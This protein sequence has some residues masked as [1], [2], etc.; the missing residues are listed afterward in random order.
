MS[1][2]PDYYRVLRVEP[3]APPALIHASFRTLMQRLRNAPSRGTHEEAALLTEAYAVLSDPERRAAYD[4]ARD[5][6]LSSRAADFAAT[7]V[8]SHPDTDFAATAV[9]APRGADF[10]ATAVL[11]PDAARYAAHS[12]LFCGTTHGLDRAIDRE[13]DCGE[14]ASPLY[15]AERQRLEPSG[16]RM[17][18]R[19]PRRR[20]V[21]LYVAW[22]Q[23]APYP[24]E[25]RD[26]SMNG[27]QLS[28]AAP[29]QQNQIVKIDCAACAT[30][31]RVAH[32]ER[33]ATPPGAPARWL[34]GVEF[35][36]L[37]FTRARHVH[38]RTRLKQSSPALAAPLARDGTLQTAHHLPPTRRARR[39]RTEKNRA[40]GEPCHATYS[41]AHWPR[42]RSRRSR[43]RAM[44]K[45]ARSRFGSTSST[46]ECSR[47]R[48]RAT[49][50]RT[51][52]S[53]KWP[54]PWRPI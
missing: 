51:P 31:A 28:T 10:A 16:K 44:R 46:A 20:A 27:M 6:A 32:C 53:R 14:C 29:L 12:C 36:T 7:T 25:M 13:D 19:I 45:T 34:V 15:P 40:T 18:R 26:L 17:L 8:L 3:D 35:L 49:G 47:P 41:R 11:D 21:E 24:A 2:D 50:S 1:P 5:V 39:R 4:L 33:E 48:R 23:P 22:P 38:L 30:V 42:S 9:L 52:T 54:C 43:S 37:R